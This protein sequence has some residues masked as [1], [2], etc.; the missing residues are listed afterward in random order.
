MLAVVAAAAIVP[1]AAP[2]G[3]SSPA[4]APFAQI[5][6]GIYHSCAVLGPG[7]ARVR[8][9]GFGADGQL[10]YANTQTIGDDEAP[11]AA[12]PVDL[13]AGRTVTALAAGDYHS[14][15]VL[16]DGSVRCW[17]FGSDGQLGL[18]GRIA[19]GDNETP[20]SAGPVNLGAGRS[21]TAITAG[22]RHTCA[23]LDGGDVRCWGLG[24]V[25]Q[26]GYENTNTILSPNLA[27]PVDFG[28]GRSARAITAGGAHTCAI[29]D[30]ASVRC[31]GYNTNG[32]LGYAS[33]TAVLSP[34]TAGPVNL[35]AGRTARAITAA[36]AHTCAVLDNGSVRCWGRNDV[37]QLGAGHQATIGDNETP[38]AVTP[39]DLGAG[40]TATAISAGGNQALAEAHTCAVLDDGSVRCWGSGALGRLGRGSLATIGDDEAPG[41]L[42]PVDLGAGRT[43]IAIS[44]GGQHTCA[45]LD[46]AGVQCWGNGADGRLGHCGVRTIGDD[47]HP[48]AVAPVDLGTGGAA[49][50]GSGAP[51]APQPAAPPAPPPGAPAPV[52]PGSATARALAAERARARSLRACRSDVLRRQRSERSSALRRHR[53]GSRSRALALRGVARRAA[54]RRVRC[55]TRFGRTPGR[56][57]TLTATRGT[58]GAV[59]LA[60]RAV[61]SAGSGPPAARRYVIKQA[62]RPIRTR[63]DFDRA[64]ALCG[65]TCTFDVTEVGDRITLRVTRLRRGTTYHYKVAARDNVSGRRGPTSPAQSVRTR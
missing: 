45:R 24:E 63:R 20:A 50:P 18:G 10:G 46:N 56:V 1:A 37:G 58:R 11:A 62:L 14:C 32:Q 52:T 61:G 33:T 4:P 22:N 65:G 2:A 34:A 59:T 7:D 64:P 21:A 38:G 13:G 28:P 55:L 25:G 48:A 26:L 54:Q 43:A 35:G 60:F 42:P 41:S 53:A 3:Q 40:R 23:L 30:D 16:D 19:I 6:T 5:A 31:W 15:A 27:G 49:C 36:A 57:R 8:C 17:G 12:G 44:A 51:P 47:E 29:L 9:W 39:V